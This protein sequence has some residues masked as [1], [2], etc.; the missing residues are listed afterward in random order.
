MLSNFTSVD[1]QHF[2]NLERLAYEIW[3]TAAALR[4]TGK[5][6]PL[7]VCGLPDSFS[8]GRSDDLDFLVTNYD[9]RLDNSGLSHSATGVE[10]SNTNALESAGVV[11]LPLY[12]LGGV[13]SKA[14]KDLL[15]LMYKVKQLY[16]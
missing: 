3:R 14:Y 7:V 9:E 13:T 10:F 4:T 11:L 6:A 16:C 5:G 12:N 15:Y 1:L 8:D 2:Y